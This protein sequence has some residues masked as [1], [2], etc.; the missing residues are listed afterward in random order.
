[1]PYQVVYTLEINAHEII[2]DFMEGGPHS[3]GNSSE[4]TRPKVSTP[5]V[6]F[7]KF[8]QAMSFAGHY[9]RHCCHTELKENTWTVGENGE[10]NVTSWLTIQD[11]HLYETLLIQQ[12]E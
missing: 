10:R 12:V 6:E 5:L 7:E 8:S 4:K 2:T 3:T 9:A 11:Y 1:M